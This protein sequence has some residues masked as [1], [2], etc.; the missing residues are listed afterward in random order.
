MRTYRQCRNVQTVNQEVTHSLVAVVNSLIQ[1]RN[2]SMF[3]DTAASP[4]LTHTGT[5][6]FETRL[7]QHYLYTSRVQ[8]HTTVG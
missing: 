3:R 7:A 4:P 6:T 2:P 1:N 8:T 5:I